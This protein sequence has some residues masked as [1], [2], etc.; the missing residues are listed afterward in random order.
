MGEDPP[1]DRTMDAGPVEAPCS[2]EMISEQRAS[3]KKLHPPARGKETLIKHWRRSYVIV[4]SPVDFQGLNLTNRLLWCSLFR[5]THFQT[6][7]I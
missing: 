3:C 1:G 6:I 5:G 2:N 4:A 7:K